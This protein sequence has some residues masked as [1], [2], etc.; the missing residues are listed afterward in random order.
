MKAAAITKPGR[1]GPWI[2]FKSMRSA[3]YL[4][5]P[6]DEYRAYAKRARGDGRLVVGV[7]RPGRH[8]LLELDPVTFKVTDRA[9]GHTK[10]EAEEDLAAKR[11][12]RRGAAP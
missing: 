7:Q 10:A 6:E 8:V 1:T 9:G 4:D 11:R 5:D 12:E 3:S 2:T